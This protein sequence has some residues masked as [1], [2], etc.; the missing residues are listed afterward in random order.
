MSEAADDDE[1]A[2]ARDLEQA[3][4]RGRLLF[5]AS[6][7]FVRGAVKPDDIPP[8]DLPEV[9]FAGRSNVGKSSLINALTGRS[10][11]ARAS[12]EPAAAPSASRFRRWARAIAPS[13][14]ARS[15]SDGQLVAW[16]SAGSPTSRYPEAVA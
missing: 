5:A 2:L 12:V 10:G 9:A 13:S 1:A 6:C 11:L 8:T 4:E 16:A 7:D 3:V 15:C 14:S